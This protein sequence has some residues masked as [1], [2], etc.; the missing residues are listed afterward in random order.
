[1]RFVCDIVRLHHTIL[2]SCLR[3]HVLVRLREIKSV[4]IQLQT[5]SDYN[6][7]W[8]TKAS[9]VS[10]VRLKINCEINH[11]QRAIANQNVLIAIMQ[12]FS[13]ACNCVVCKAYHIVWNQHCGWNGICERSWVFV[14]ETTLTKADLFS[15]NH[16]NRIRYGNHAVASDRHN[17]NES[18]Y[19]RDL[20][21]LSEYIFQNPWIR[22]SNESTVRTTIMPINSIR[23]SRR[24]NIVDFNWFE[25]KRKQ[26][27]T[28]EWFRFVFFFFWV[29]HWI[30]HVS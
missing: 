7:R 10:R 16:M 17:N 3:A 13:C 6:R 30:E 15:H 11:I 18:I 29:Q 28:S 5:A 22:E 25:M 26:K 24:R 4:E 20:S 8:D 1:M 9:N 12:L 21:L 27:K 19:E 2:I 14:L 23:T